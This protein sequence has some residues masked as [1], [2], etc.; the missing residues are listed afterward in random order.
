M[1]ARERVRAAYER[2]AE[3]DRPE[4]WIEL[5]RLE[6]A[7]ADAAAVDE[8]VAAGE[9]LP[10]AGA[11]LAVKDNIDIA[12]MPTTA[13]CPR[14]AYTPTL[15]APAVSRLVDAGAIALG[16]TNMD[17][18]ATGLVGTRSP[19]GAVRDV[20][21]ADRVS[22]GSSSGSAVAVALG[23]ADI[24]LGTD[25]AGSGRVPAAFQGIVGLKPTRGLVPMLGVVP[26]CR[27]LDCVSVLA[28]EL[29]EA[30]LAIDLMTAP[31]P[32][33]TSAR[34][35]PPDAP[36]AAPPAPRVA[37][38]VAFDELTPAGCSVFDAAVARLFDAGSELVEID[39]SP[40]LEAGRLL[41]GGGFVA[42]RYAAVGEFI[43]AHWDE[44]D[45]IVG[46]IIEA[47]ESIPAH[48]QAGDVE[49]LDV[50]R[51]AARRELANADALLVPTAPSQPTIA[52]VAADPVGMNARLG[53]YT[54]F[55]NL[56]GLCAVAVPAG[57]ADGGQFGVTVMAPAFADRV[58]ADVARLLVGGRR[59]AA[60]VG[61][62]GVKLVVVGAHRAG[63]PLNHQL[64]SRGARLCGVV[65]TAPEYRLYRLDTD[66]PRPG[67]A[68][69][70][71]GG[72][73]I[74]AELWEL[75]PAGLGEF[76]TDVPPPLAIGHVR[77]ADGSEPLGFLCEGA[78]L[79]SAEDITA[80]ESWIAYMGSADSRQTTVDRAAY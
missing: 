72:A 76:M 62:P 75:P 18:F 67:L 3:V 15:S 46:A 55:C 31:A 56:L 61:P 36:L 79:D 73:A 16:K 57:E 21:R 70:D 47:A 54:S 43:G 40:F 30:E 68:R 33:D 69:T 20:R 5:R 7:L 27:T 26:A 80:F 77:L 66:P 50:L 8:R 2:I 23:I 42:E 64:T 25:T 60:G 1:S 71:D 34:T 63:Q 24:G 28:R 37:V 45:P 29:A 32:G 11:T 6:D 12:G 39:L 59:P 13:G 58:A 48:R 9:D 78:A 44:V 52:E 10:L 49:R 65:R 14:F 38:P 19:Y 35:W 41:Y 17:Q 51:L 22:G 74:E 4:V 53:T